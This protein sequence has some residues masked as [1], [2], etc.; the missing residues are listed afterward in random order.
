MLQSEIRKVIELFDYET[1]RRE[2]RK[3]FHEHGV[4]FYDKHGEGFIRNG[5][6]HY[7]DTLNNW[8]TGH[9]RPLW[10]PYNNLISKQTDDD[11]L[12]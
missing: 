5:V 4:R 10:M 8:H 6:K 9:S 2:L 3:E 12:R 1:R 7:C 11:H